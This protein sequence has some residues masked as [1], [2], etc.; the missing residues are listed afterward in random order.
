MNILLIFYLSF[1]RNPNQIP[2]ARATCELTSE[3]ADDVVDDDDDGDSMPASIAA[4]LRTDGIG[5]RPPVRRLS[6]IFTD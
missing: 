2:G 1:T 5:A 4:T 3:A 6:H